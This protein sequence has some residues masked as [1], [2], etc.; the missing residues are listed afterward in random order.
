MLGRGRVHG[1]H[2]RPPRRVDTRCAPGAPGR[3]ARA[4]TR[5]ALP[6]P[7]TRPA[8]PGHQPA[9][10]ERRGRDH[11]VA[12]GRHGDHAV[13]AAAG[14]NVRGGGEV[15]RSPACQPSALVMAWSTTW[16]KAAGRRAV[17]NQASPS[18][19]PR[20]TAQRVSSRPVC[21]SL[22]R[23]GPSR[24]QIGNPGMPRR[25]AWLRSWATVGLGCWGRAL[26]R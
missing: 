17:I 9:A 22:S 1:G 20:V 7:G 14:H 2:S 16:Q 21:L 12:L 18:W 19:P 4:S 13:Q 8:A 26:D 15:S 5:P 11:D 24:G 25:G 3:P 6:P 10:A 23:K